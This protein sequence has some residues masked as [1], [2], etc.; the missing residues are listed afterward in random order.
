LDTVGECFTPEAQTLPVHTPIS[1]SCETTPPELRGNILNY[2]Y[3]IS[4]AFLSAN[5]AS[6]SSSEYKTTQ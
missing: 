1:V 3:P 5:N 2:Q 6:F 4:P